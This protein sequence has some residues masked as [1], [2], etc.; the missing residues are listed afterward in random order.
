MKRILLLILSLMLAAACAASAE[1]AFESWLP[2]GAAEVSQIDAG[3]LRILTYAIS[4]TGEQ[5]TLTVDAATGDVRM[6]YGMCAAAGEGAPMSADSAKAILETVYPGALVISSVEEAT[7]IGT[8]RRLNIVSA[9]LCGYVLF[10]SEKICGRDLDFTGCMKD[11]RL[12]MQGAISVLKL[13]RPEATI[14]EI[15]LDDDD[16]LLL[17]EGS[18]H[19]DGVEYE[20]E[21]NAH[22]GKLLQWDRD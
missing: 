15:E 22:T 16:G 8:L 10:D 2:E 12:T 6:L 11:G 13:L 5:L 18:A 21:L 14:S 3:G 17:Y 19:L 20:F 4:D 7:D 1:T 9:D